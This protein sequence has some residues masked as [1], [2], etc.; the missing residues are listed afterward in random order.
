MVHS[1]L[2]DHDRMLEQTRERLL[3]N[4]PWAQKAFERRLIESQIPFESE[5]I[6]GFYL[7]DIVVP[8]KLIVIDLDGSIH[9]ESWQRLRDKRKDAFLLI[10]IGFY[11]VRIRN[12]DLETYSLAEIEAFRDVPEAEYLAAIRL[13]YDKKREF[14]SE[15]EQEIA[16]RGKI[17]V[18]PINDPSDPSEF[19][20]VQCKRCTKQLEIHRSSKIS[21]PYFCDPCRSKS[22]TT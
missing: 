9:D 16:C 4:P 20:W 15:R 8:H 1:I 14:F 11:I 7:A 12:V 2:E 18:E 22:L 6:I 5:V 3:R 17:S 13:A 21:S 19:V 10:D